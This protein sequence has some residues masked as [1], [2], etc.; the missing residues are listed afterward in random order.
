MFYL[1]FKC[2]FLQAIGSQFFFFLGRKLSA[3][4]QPDR[5]KKS[6]TQEALIAQQ[7]TAVLSKQFLN[8][9]QEDFQATGS[10]LIKSK[11]NSP[12]PVHMCWDTVRN[13]AHLYHI[14][15]GRC[16]PRDCALW[17]SIFSQRSHIQRP[18]LLSHLIPVNPCTY[19][20]RGSDFFPA[21]PL[22]KRLWS[23]FW[24]E[25]HETLMRF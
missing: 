16:C 15:C 9:K 14:I 1:G 3:R 25:I 6:L 13:A 5:Q 2:I 23:Y 22:Q 12:V 21:T 10:Q 20:I 18:I 11:N 8:T 4:T 19:P 17:H 24:K 7:Q